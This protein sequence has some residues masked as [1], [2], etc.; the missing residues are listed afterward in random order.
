[1]G[2]T[3][4]TDPIRRIRPDP[5]G[6]DTLS[7]PLPHG[8][9]RRSG[10][11]LRRPTCQ[12]KISPL[13]PIAPLTATIPIALMPCPVGPHCPPAVTALL[14]YASSCRL[15]RPP[16][17]QRVCAAVMPGKSCS[18]IS[19][20]QHIATCRLPRAPPRCQ[21]VSSYLRRPLHRSHCYS[22]CVCACCDVFRLCPRQP[23]LRPFYPSCA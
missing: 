4:C 18:S 14:A 15:V 22:A 11:S 19:H 23:A 8:L 5:T 9:T 1:V 20:A 2:R 17:L 16:L 10:S 12:G 6:L 21:D 13:A 7:A 3:Y